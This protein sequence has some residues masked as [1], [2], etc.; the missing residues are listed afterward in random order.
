M[1]W[2]K[3]KRMKTPPGHENGYPDPMA[4]GWGAP[5]EEDD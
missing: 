5:E 3:E 4:G 2:Y 1:I